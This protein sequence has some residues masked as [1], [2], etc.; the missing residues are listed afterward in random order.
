MFGLPRTAVVALTVA[1]GLALVGVIV[2]QRFD[3]RLVDTL[4]L[5]CVLAGVHIAALTNTES[6]AR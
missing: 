2:V 3:A 1:F 5:A 6:G 4:G